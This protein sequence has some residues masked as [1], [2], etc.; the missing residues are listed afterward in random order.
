[1]DASNTNSDV[2]QFYMFDLEEVIPDALIKYPSL[3]TRTE[4]YCS[5]LPSQTTYELDK[6]YKLIK[7]QSRWAC[8]LYIANTKTLLMSMQPQV[9]H[10]LRLVQEGSRLRSS[11]VNSNLIGVD[12]G[13][14][15]DFP[16][17]NLKLATLY[18]KSLL[19]TMSKFDT[20]GT[21]FV[22]PARKSPSFDWTDQY[23]R[24]T[25]GAKANLR[26]E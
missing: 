24:I 7:I 13:Q 20:F 26:S 15:D 6:L 14:V 4:A 10:E 25:D 22:Q 12:F 3:L 17:K 5:L 16:I 21:N 8:N 11:V 19:G 23:I 18:V 2:F 1:M 9:S